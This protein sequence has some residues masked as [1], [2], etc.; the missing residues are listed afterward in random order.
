MG[1]VG[2]ASGAA[3]DALIVGGGPAGSS[4]AGA[5]RRAGLD[6][7]VLDAAL[8]PRDKVCAGWITPQVVAALELDVDEYRR[9]RTF[10]P[11][12]RFRVALIDG[13]CQTE[14]DY[15][16]D[17]S[18]GIRRC[19]F[20]HY[21]LQRS[22]ARV[23]T[24]TSVT[25][26]E[27]AGHEWIVNG[28]I[29]T[30]LLIGAGGHFCPVARM[31][32]GPMNQQSG[33][34]VVVAQEAEFPVPMTPATAAA[35]AS[36]IQ[37]E[38]PE[39]YFCRDFKGY[40]WCF[41][42]G[43][44]LNVG[45][46]RLDRRSLPKATVE[47]V[48]FLRATGRLQGHV[49]PRWRGHAYAVYQTPLRRVVEPGAVLIGDAAGLA[50]AQSGEGIRPAVESGLLAAA[51]ILDANRQYSPARLA[52]YAE[53]LRARFGARTLSSIPS[54]L[55]NVVPED[56]GAAVGRRLLA[57]PA[58]VRHVVLDRWFLHRHKPALG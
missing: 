29:R 25:T 40:G 24:G 15:G 43:D 10:Q 22:G 3:C 37:G 19:E 42:K 6:V 23:K 4:C 47:F 31:I 11:I 48:S 45:L 51:A 26:L 21:L 54:A 39:L 55:S 34:P 52:A 53:R 28:T 46:G 35:G 18:Y 1:A 13:A 50:Y 38:A 44:Y 30:P 12:S 9:G 58:F 56:V 7:M 17:V 27:R 2:P 32:N 16:Q 41:R 33:T 14:T 57:A 49:S 20:D 5:L 8:F 36:P